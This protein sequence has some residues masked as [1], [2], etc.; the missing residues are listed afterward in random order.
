MNK[1]FK[2]VKKHKTL[3][4]LL[5]LLLLTFLS[6]GKTWQMY[7]WVDDL[8]MTYKLVWPQDALTN[9]A[10]G[11]LGTGPYRYLITPFA[12]LYP[13]FDLNP[14]PYF[15]LGWVV[16]FLATVSVYLL[17]LELTQKRE[18]A[19][20][21]ASIFASGYIGA[22]ALYRLT[23]SY[24]TVGA[25][26]LIILSVWVFLKYLPPFLPQLLWFDLYHY[27]IRNSYCQ[28]WEQ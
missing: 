2:L 10:P 24:Q 16:Y 3:S 25:T 23:N 21:A 8:A 4:I 18:P 22:H 26:A 7:Y 19:F 11:I 6:H 14:F 17:T 1:L 20:V 27:Q 28:W 12:L 9:M 13:L 5:S 15:F